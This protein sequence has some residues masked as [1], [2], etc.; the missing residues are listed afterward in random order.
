M[1]WSVSDKQG[2]TKEIKL[3]QFAMNY[4]DLTW[5]PSTSMAINIFIR[6]QL[7]WN[8]KCNWQ[9]LGASLQWN[10]DLLEQLLCKKTY[11]WTVS[12]WLWYVELIRSCL[13]LVSQV[14]GPRAQSGIY[15]NC[16]WLLTSKI[17]WHINCEKTFN[18]LHVDQRLP[19][20][21]RH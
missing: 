10:I 17:K 4:T 12:R 2:L 13:Y 20:V 15:K 21:S 6:L 9:D 3:R 14:S 5:T 11:F 19:S 8:R 16:P 7:F 18:F 1:C